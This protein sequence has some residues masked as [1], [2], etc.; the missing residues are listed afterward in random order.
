MEVAETTKRAKCGH[1]PDCSFCPGP[2][3][4]CL[5]CPTPPRKPE[6]GNTISSKPG[7]RRSRQHRTPRIHLRSRSI[8]RGNQLLRSLS[9]AFH[10]ERN[11]PRAIALRR[12]PPGKRDA[13]NAST[14]H[15]AICAGRGV[16]RPAGRVHAIP[17][18]GDRAPQRRRPRARWRGRR[19]GRPR[20]CE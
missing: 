9:E 20:P 19:T 12:R 13:K 7:R 5:E 18:A 15:R 10:A 1:D 3:N 11:G 4:S 17:S 6:F 16:R 2:N 14:P 8:L